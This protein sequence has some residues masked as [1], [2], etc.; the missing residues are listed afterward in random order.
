MSY[1]PIKDFQNQW[2]ATF[3]FRILNKYEKIINK[4][5]YNQ[6]LEIDM[7]KFGVKENN[8]SNPK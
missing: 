6:K 2:N 3:F 8:L 1:L 5:Q 4:N 7:F